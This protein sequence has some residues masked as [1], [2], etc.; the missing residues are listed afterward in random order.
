MI[1]VRRPLRQPVGLYY[2]R[3]GGDLTGVNI[4]AAALPPREAAQ[5]AQSSR[6]RAV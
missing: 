6:S 5:A 1:A 4:A 2:S 3:R